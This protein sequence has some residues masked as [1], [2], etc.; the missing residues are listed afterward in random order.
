MTNPRSSAEPHTDMPG[1]A[2]QPPEAKAAKPRRT[3]ARRFSAPA[4]APQT[5]GPGTPALLVLGADGLIL[6]P[7]SERRPTSPAVSGP[8]TNDAET[9]VADDA[10]LNSGAQPADDAPGPDVEASP[11]TPVDEHVDNEEPD[12]VPSAVQAVAEKA[13]GAGDSDAPAAADGNVDDDRPVTA[14]STTPA[15]APDGA[16]PGNADDTA[17]ATADLEEPAAQQSDETSLAE[18]EGASGATPLSRRERRMAEQTV[19][20]AVA[21]AKAAPSTRAGEPRPTPPARAGGHK[22]RRKPWRVVRG[23]L[24]F[25]VIAAVVLGMGT[26][27]T[28]KDARNDAPSATES[29]R[30]QAWTRTTDLLAQARAL[31]SSTADASMK[32]LLASTT[33]ALEIQ[34][35]ALSNGLPGAT[36]GPTA[37]A[38][39]A[40]TPAT[41]SAALETS[42]QTLLK[43]SLTA[44]DALGRTFAAAGTNQLLQATAIDTILGRAAPQSPFPAATSAGPAPTPR[45]DATPTPGPGLNAGAALAAAALAEQKAVYAYQVAGTRL[46]EPAFTRAVGLIAAHQARLDR[47]NGELAAQCLPQVPLSPGFVLDA[48]F[49]RDPAHALAGLEGQLVLVY[50]DL[51]ALSEPAPLPQPSTPA[52]GSAAAPSAGSSASQSGTSELRSLAVA[53]LLGS[54]LDQQSWGGTVG[55]LPGIPDVPTNTAPVKP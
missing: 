53:W 18:E 10:S 20:A 47:L 55:P 5:S 9:K 42:A 21:P 19:P 50:G 6:A 49:T 15:A 24:L 33:A 17:A 37:T 48:A 22:P 52:T 25:A 44:Q 2:P 3:G 31:H 4:G 16:E 29:N 46:P 51:A 30:A 35:A 38:A 23:I 45:C 41:F 34:L 11:A 32:T 8:V 54:A 14:D 40:A 43:D 36:S 1:D 39:A 26:V 13:G 27:I 28:G 7:S 12:A